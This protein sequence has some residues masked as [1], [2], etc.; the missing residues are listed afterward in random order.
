MWQDVKKI[1]LA[2][3]RFVITTHLNPD[4]DGVG[5]ATAFSNLLSQLQKKSIF[6]CDTPVG[7]KFSFLAFAGE[8]ATSLEEVKAFNPQVLIVLDAHAKERIGTLRSLSNSPNVITFCIDHHQPSASLSPLSVIDPQSCSTGAMIYTLFKEMGLQLTL[9]AAKG[10]YVSILCDTGRFS[11]SSTNRKAHKIAN[12]C[13]KVGVDPDEIYS[14][15]FE[16]IGSEMF[17]VFQRAI[18][19]SEFYL[20]KK[21]LIQSIFLHDTI[22]LPEGALDLDWLHEV[23]KKVVEVD[24]SIILQEL[25]S[26]LI[27]I[28]CR[29]KSFNALD[30]VKPFGGGGHK[31]AAGAQAKILLDEAKEQILEKLSCRKNSILC[32]IS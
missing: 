30:I 9:D 4:G 12:E 17:Q 26:E 22:H 21:V 10:L 28:S 14:N 20:G 16:S 29:T 2:N 8:V 7:E 6:Y 31:K 19:R 18:G 1:L 5:S 25:D 11:N 27:R 23:N 32:K 24:A 3:D 13:I 15:L